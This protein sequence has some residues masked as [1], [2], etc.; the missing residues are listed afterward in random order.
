MSPHDGRVDH[1]VII[2]RVI[3]QSL[4]MTLPNAALGPAREAG[5]DVFQ[6]PEALRQV[7]QRRRY[8]NEERPHSE[9]GQMT[10]ILLHNT[11]GASSPSPV[12]EAE[13]SGL[14]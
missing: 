6:G 1:R 11:D 5:V 2:V 14:R 9:I 8:Y 4:Q 10:P 3:C 12:K 13:N 7:T